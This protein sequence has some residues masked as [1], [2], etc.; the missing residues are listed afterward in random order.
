MKLITKFLLTTLIGI[1]CLNAMEQPQ[2]FSMWD[3]LYKELSGVLNSDDQ[4]LF[5]ATDGA[6]PTPKKA[7]AE[8][9]QPLGNEKA[10]R[11]LIF[12]E[13]ESTPFAERSAE[14]VSIITSDEAEIGDKTDAEKVPAQDP[15]R[16]IGLK[17]KSTESSKT[18]YKK[19]RN[20][21]STLQNPFA[22]KQGCG[23]TFTNAKDAV[24]HFLSQHKDDVSHVLKKRP[25]LATIISDAHF[26]IDQKDAATVTI[27]AE[28]KRAKTSVFRPGLPRTNTAPN[29]LQNPFMCRKEDC[30]KVC[31]DAK[32]YVDHALS[33]KK[34]LQI[35]SKNF[36]TAKKDFE[37]K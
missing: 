25:S 4:K 19:P 12:D 3:E 14:T 28:R 10:R 5:D 27:D 36:F 31:V 22:C 29:T 2:K 35:T 9:L 37:K 15:K 6:I 17:Q 24:E 26:D 34:T 30:G 16:N 1:H 11:T 23:T 13:S 7:F 8:S 18:S 21:P 20:A 33:H 32:E